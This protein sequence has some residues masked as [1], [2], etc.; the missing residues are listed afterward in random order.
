MN[1]V[2]QQA[3]RAANHL[4]VSLY[5]RSGGRIGGK[6][7]GTTV[8]LL[9]VPGRKTGRPRTVPISY[10]EHHGELIVTG[11]AG[12]MKNN[13]QW[14][15]NLKAAGAGDIQIGSDR[16]SVHARVTEGSE[17]DELWEQ[18]ILVRAPFFA[19]Y[20]EKSGR[21]IPIAVLT[22]SGGPNRS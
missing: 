19:T 22:R 1:P 13:P 9:T 18:V 11:S 4:A 21:T 3:M 15:R 8:L 7:K 2:A 12:G 6:A 17:R 16:S 14:I 20:E 10:F 5:R